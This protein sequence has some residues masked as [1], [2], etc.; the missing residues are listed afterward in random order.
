M[1]KVIKAYLIAALLISTIGIGVITS[2]AEISANDEDKEDSPQDLPLPAGACENQPWIERRKDPADP[3][4]Q[5]LKKPS[6]KIQP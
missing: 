5:F 3:N 1:N 4:F 2:V 6:Q